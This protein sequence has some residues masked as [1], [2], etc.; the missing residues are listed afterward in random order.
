MNPVKLTGEY[1]VIKVLKKSKA[2]YAKGINPGDVIRFELEMV[3]TSGASNGNYVL[4]AD[5]YVNGVLL[6]AVSQN[7]FHRLTRIL[8]LSEK[9]KHTVK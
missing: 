8:D 3:N 1:K 2:R 6:T 5:M 7:D 4:Y 9:C